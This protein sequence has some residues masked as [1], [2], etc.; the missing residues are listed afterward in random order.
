MILGVFAS[1]MLSMEVC[2]QVPVQVIVVK[3]AE[4]VE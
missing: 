3:Y 2:V 1:G 4:E